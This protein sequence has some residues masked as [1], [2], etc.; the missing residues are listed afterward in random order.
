MMPSKIPRNSEERKRLLKAF[1]AL[2]PEKA[3]ALERDL[4]ELLDSG[5]RGGAGALVA[6]SEYL[7]VV[8]TKR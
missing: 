4:T 1:G 8:I 6:P 2:P 5:N 7:E 3:A